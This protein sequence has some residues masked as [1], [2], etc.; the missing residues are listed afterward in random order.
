MDDGPLTG[1]L[2]WDEERETWRC[3]V[4]GNDGHSWEIFVHLF[5]NSHA[6]DE[7][8]CEVFLLDECPNEPQCDPYWWCGERAL[9]QNVPCWT[10][11][12]PAT[13][14]ASPEGDNS[15]LQVYFHHE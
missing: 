15:L 2:S 10:S 12:G 7:W 6:E 4:E 1:C 11:C 14:E 8:G 3:E 5:D 13:W 9:P